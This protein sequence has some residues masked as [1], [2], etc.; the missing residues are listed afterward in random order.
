VN[1]LMRVE[2]RGIGSDKLAKKIK[3]A[4]DFAANGAGSVRLAA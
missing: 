1:V 3:L 4:A 2:V